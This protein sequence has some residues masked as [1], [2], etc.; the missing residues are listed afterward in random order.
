MSETVGV[1]GASPRMR[2]GVKPVY[3]SQG[4]RISLDHAIEFARAATDGLRIPRP[5]READHF[6]EAVKRC[7]MRWLQVS[8]K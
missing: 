3:I 7:E 2:E 6:V 4:H 5:T 1:I 8:R